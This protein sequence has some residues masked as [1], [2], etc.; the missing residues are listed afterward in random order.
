ML[1]LSA[2]LLGLSATSSPEIVSL[3]VSVTSSISGPDAR[4]QIGLSTLAAWGTAPDPAPGFRGYYRL[5]WSTFSLNIEGRFDLPS[6]GAGDEFDSVE[7]SMWLLGIAPCFAYHPQL[8]LCLTLES[9]TIYLDSV[10][11]S[12]QEL[13]F[14]TQMGFRGIILAGSWQGLGLEA[15]VGVAGSI[16]RAQIW[17][18]EEANY[19]AWQ[20]AGVLAAD[21]ALSFNYELF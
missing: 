14:Y 21:I 4:H 13:L 2:L 7:S 17:A 10:R 18:D 1:A 6:S 15:S 5:S 16:V 11:D 20:D 3:P 9:G 8:S 19:R 12:S